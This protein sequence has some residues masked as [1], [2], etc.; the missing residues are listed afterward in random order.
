[1]P[2]GLRRKAQDAP[3]LFSVVLKFSVLVFQVFEISFYCA[4]YK[5]N[6][7]FEVFE[8]FRFNRTGNALRFFSQGTRIL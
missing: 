2:P 3:I 4:I 5:I 7:G 1:M 8:V 6:R